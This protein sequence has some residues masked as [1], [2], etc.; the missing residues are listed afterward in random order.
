[1]ETAVKTVREILQHRHQWIVP[2]YQ[3]HY[4]WES[5]KEAQIPKLWETMEEKALERLSESTGDRKEIPH[6]FGA[7]ICEDVKKEN[8]G[9]GFEEKIEYDY[10]VDGQQRITSFQIALIAIREVAKLYKVADIV[11]EANEHIFNREVSGSNSASEENFKLRPSKMDRPLFEAIACKGFDRFTQDHSDRFHPKTQKPINEAEKLIWA[12]WMLCDEIK[13]MVEQKIGDEGRNPK[14]VLNALLKGFLDGF[15]VVIIRL[16]EEDDAQ[17]IFESLNGKGKP[18]SRFDLVRNNIFL[19]ARKEGG[20]DWESVLEREWEYFEDKFWDQKVRRGRLGGPRAEHLIAHV[21]VA[22]TARQVGVDKIATEYSRHVED[23]G[24]GSVD[25]E[26]KALKRYA[27]TYRNLEEYKDD[28]MEDNRVTEIAKV[29]DSW[30]TTTF[31]PL[32]LWVC[33]YIEDEKVQKE[34]FD[35]IESFLVRRQICGL[36]ER[37]YN[38]LVPSMI[39]KMMRE[40]GGAVSDP[41]YALREYI[42]NAKS[43]TSKMP[44]DKEVSEAF[45][46]NQTAMNRRVRYILVKLEY[47]KRSH[48]SERERL[49]DSNLTLEHIMPKAWAKEWPLPNGAQAPTEDIYDSKYQDLDTDIRQMIQRRSVAVSTYGN[50]TLLTNRLNPT[51]SNKGWKEKKQDID[52][53]SR[54]ILNQEIVKNDVWDEEVIAKRAQELAQIA[55]DIW[56]FTPTS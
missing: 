35:L 2:V 56:K 27:G 34:I 31:H 21:V 17:E 11:D 19:R 10:L 54:L 18:L 22:E 44:Q 41:A 37:N 24:Y 23:K 40:G 9:V 55:I 50:F 7:I 16:D 32:V 46:R 3:R 53:H 39:G 14:E 1:M 12:Y 4:E 29:F 51:V 36:T 28:F 25:K 8:S 30:D 42:T 6:Y 20:S 47:A 45:E 13:Q 26:V 33:Y 49:D 52:K 5:A 48:L 15:K 43:N 38:N